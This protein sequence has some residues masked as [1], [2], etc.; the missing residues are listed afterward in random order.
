M[1]ALFLLGGAILRLVANAL[2]EEQISTLRR[3]SLKRIP[4]GLEV[5]IVEL[6]VLAAYLV[7]VLAVPQWSL[8]LWL[9]AVILCQISGMGYLF[10]LAG[11]WRGWTMSDCLFERVMSTAEERLQMDEAVI[12]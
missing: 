12:Q 7:G 5:W 1:W 10:Y 6:G 8:R 4:G 9:V 11:Y 2:V 3:R